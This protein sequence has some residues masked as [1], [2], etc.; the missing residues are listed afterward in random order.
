VTGNDGMQLTTVGDRI[1]DRALVLTT[2]NLPHELAD[3]LNRHRAVSGVIAVGSSAPKDCRPLKKA[4][5]D[6]LFGQDPESGRAY[7][8][9]EKA[10]FILPVAPG[11]LGPIKLIDQIALVPEGVD[12]VVSSTGRICANAFEVLDAVFSQCDAI[13]DDRL[14]CSAPVDKVWLSDRRHR[15]VLINRIRSSKHPVAL[16]VVAQFDPF[17]NI[18]VVEG[19]L[20]L[21]E[22]CG[23]NVML[24][25]TDMAAVQ[26]IARGGCAA[27]ISGTASLR[28]SVPPFRRS[29]KRQNN[30]QKPSA[31]V[32]MP[33]INEFRDV[34]QLER[35]FGERKMPVCQLPDCCGRK[36][37]DFNPGNND[38]KRVLAG[39]NV[40]GM[41]GILDSMLTSPDRR[42]W[43]RDY[44][45]GITEALKELRSRSGVPD[46]ELYASGEVWRALDD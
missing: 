8:A 24:H 38:D 1:R 26:F 31:A 16:S 46:I 7:V 23:H 35:W 29:Q 45:D 4:S 36:L 37:N 11:F 6:M 28:H 43:L 41:L 13:S 18:Q 3:I 25:R 30:K 2:S 27:G 33:G 21:V 40:R 19:L 20:E 9:T 34:A 10:P 14:A 39:H 32:F 5:P 22:T 15:A 17:E 42:S 44:R 12:L